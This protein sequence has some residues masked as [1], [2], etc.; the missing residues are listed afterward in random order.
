MKHSTYMKATALLA[1]AFTGISAYSQSDIPLRKI[2][3]IKPPG[4]QVNMLDSVKGDNYRR[5]Y[6]YNE[7]GYITS[8]MA[9]HKDADW[10]LDTGVSY[11]QDYVFNDNGVCTERTRYK[12]DENGKRTIVDDMGKLE[13]KDDLTWEYSYAR[14]DDG[15][16][17]PATARAYDKWGNLTIDM[18]YETDGTSY[19]DYISHYEETRYS[20]PV[21]ADHI[22][23]NTFKEA[24]RTYHLIAANDGLRTMDASELHVSYCE[25]VLWEQLNGNLY[26]ELFYGEDLSG[27]TVGKVKKYL[28]LTSEEIYELNDEGTRPV[29]KC[30]V[31]MSGTSRKYSDYHEYTWDDKNRLLSE[32][33]SPYI[34]GTV[35]RKYTYTY[36][37]DYAP[38]KSLMDAVYA[39]RN[40]F[41]QYPEDE[42][43]TFGR[44]ATESSEHVNEGSEN[45]SYTWNDQGQLVE[46]KWKETGTEYDYDTQ[47][48]QQYEE[49]GE[50]HYFYNADGHMAYLIDVDDEDGIAD[51]T[52]IEFVYD[53]L[54]RWT[55]EKEYSGTSFDGPWHAEYANSA[56]V[57]TGN[58]PLKSASFTDDMSDGYHDIYS[59]DG[60]FET[61]GYYAVEDGK[62]VSGSYNRYIVNTA[63]IPENPE[64]NYT[65]PAV[66]FE[67]MDDCDASSMIGYWYYLWDNTSGKWVCVQAP[68]YAN[69]IYHNGDD[70]V[71]DTYNRDEQITSTTTYSF[72]GDGRLAKQSGANCEIVYT[73]LSDG[74]DYL[75]E[76][77]TT[78]DGVSSTLHY[79]Y[80]L[81]NYMPT[82]I[83]DVKTSTKESVYYD[84][85][86]RRIKNPSAHGIYIV[87]GKKVMK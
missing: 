58:S 32:T 79:Y 22:K 16:L 47:T 77:V 71:C 55:G 29:S 83:D 46:G 10:S 48:S 43:C 41:W 11:V 85:Q 81:H 24:Y 57:R 67:F 87:N 49:N 18:E 17:H 30:L 66:P 78:T 21:P 31:D 15:K 23:E 4:I 27:V 68:D 13:V 45:V 12:V 20:G 61:S 38:E 69:H 1:L 56:K 75:L 39:I 60:V 50:E 51:Y 76:T 84:L 73:Y 52:K 36:A 59:N 82:D 44:L 37:D 25:M 53:E 65:E 54:G 5:I 26:R 9:Y 72:D 40:N 19:E 7:Y 63:S 35:T 8:V 80:S 70:I 14:D 86:G 28:K 62:I 3:A 33:Y 6:Q 42:Y 74:S 34:G 64:L 2:R